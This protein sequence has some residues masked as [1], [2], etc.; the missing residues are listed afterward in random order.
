MLMKWMMLLAVGLLAVGV[1]VACAAEGAAAPGALNEQSS[2]D[3][4]LDALDM[5]GDTM[6]DFRAGVVYTEEDNDTALFTTRTGQVRFARQ[7]DG[8]AKMYVEFKDRS[9]NERRAVPE[10][11]IFL[12]DP[13]WLIERDFRGRKEIRRK[14]IREGETI[15]LLKLGEGPFPLPLGQD[16]QDV[17]AEFEVEKVAADEGDPQGSLHIRLTPK[18]G[19]Q[20]HRRYARV[21]VWVDMT[22][23]MPVRVAIEDRNGAKTRTTELSEIQVNAGLQEGDFTLPPIPEGW[24][25]EEGAYEEMDE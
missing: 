18:P 19:R 20:F 9:V 6:K 23:H 25:R 16:R 13:P 21:D 17:Y 22:S 8:Q 24:T 15:N 12:L 3:Q 2:V 10:R 4:I 14:V 11:A 1:E 5:R 7:A